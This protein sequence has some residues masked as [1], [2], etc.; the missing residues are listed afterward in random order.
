MCHNLVLVLNLIATSG[1]GRARV[2]AG[3][4][5]VHQSVLGGTLCTPVCTRWY[6]VFTSLY[7]VVLYIRQ[8]VLGGILCTLVSTWCYSM[9]M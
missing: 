4:W 2:Y 9:S 6:S 1:K 5:D 3:W 8:S 7:L